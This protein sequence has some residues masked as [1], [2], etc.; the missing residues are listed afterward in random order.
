M[1]DI[2]GAETN[3]LIFYQ[4]ELETLEARRRVQQ[5]PEVEEVERTHG[6][7]DLNLLN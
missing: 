1:Y 5:V 2:G 3:H 7:D 6:L 4:P